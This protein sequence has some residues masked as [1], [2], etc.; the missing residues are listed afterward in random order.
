MLVQNPT[1]VRFIVTGKEANKLL[2]ESAPAGRT[3]AIELR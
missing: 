3:R 1:D 2:P